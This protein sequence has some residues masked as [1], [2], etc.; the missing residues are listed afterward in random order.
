M[1]DCL[2]ELGCSTQICR[3]RFA[4]QGDVLLRKMFG[5]CELRLKALPLLLNGAPASLH[6]PCQEQTACQEG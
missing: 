4:T 6:D 1:A 3:D 5:L 2:F